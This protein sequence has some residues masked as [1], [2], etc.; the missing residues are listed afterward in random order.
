[1]NETT[2]THIS[3]LHSRSDPRIYQKEC[4]SLS[5]KYKTILVVA[6][7]LGNQHINNTT[8]IDLGKRYSLSHRLFSLNKKAYK[9]VCKL[10]PDIVHIHDPELMPITLLIK[11]NI[12]CKL[13]YDAHE[14]LPLQIQRKPWIPKRIRPLASIV[15]KYSLSL[16]MKNFDLIVTATPSIPTYSHKNT[17]TIHN[18]PHKGNIS[19]AREKTHLPLILGYAGSLSFERGLTDMLNIAS[20][21]RKLILAGKFIN[22]STENSAKNHPNWKHVDYRGY[23][24]KNG[25]NKLYTDTDIG[26]LLLK[27]GIGFEETLPTKLFEYM[28]AGI[29]TL[30]SNIPKWKSIIDKFECGIATEVKNKQLEAAINQLKKKETY[31]KMSE[32]SLD[33]AKHFTWN[34]EEEKL[35]K[36]YDQFTNIP[37]PTLNQNS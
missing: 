25:I 24:D 34:S 31:K 6:D 15:T 11:L 1:M 20:P 4:L 7:G 27:K 29:P 23:L 33:A 16:L 14:D 2:I 36:S 10:R 28:S 35:L 19:S 17:I 12:K 18:Y 30:C 5:K 32:N 26:L 22:K 9:T 13:I 37:K 3:T 8:I 21:S